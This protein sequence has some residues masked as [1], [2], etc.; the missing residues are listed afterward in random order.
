MENENIKFRRFPS[1]LSG[2]AF[3]NGMVLHGG[4]K[5][6][7]SVKTGSGETVSVKYFRKSGNT[8]KI[9]IPVIG[10]AVK[11]LRAACSGVKYSAKAFKLNKKS[12]LVRMLKY[13][14][15]EHK[16]IHCYENGEV[17]TLENVRKQPT[18][19]PRCGTSVAANTLIAEGLILLLVPEKIGSLLGGTMDYI[20]LLGA[21]GIGFET[22]GYASK[23]SGAWARAFALPGKLAQKITALEPDDEMILLGIQTAE[24]LIESETPV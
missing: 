10:G 14:G 23:R 16:V 9:K 20:L 17:L 1:S 21:L 5:S 13:H 4:G 11:M 18:Y 12:S 15:A 7:L 2:R 22:A 19:H 24:A 6:V 3:S 8:T